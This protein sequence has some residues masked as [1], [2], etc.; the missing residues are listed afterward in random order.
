MEEL[1]KKYIEKLCESVPIFSILQA[2]RKVYS[3][4]PHGEYWLHDYLYTKLQAAFALDESTFKCDEFYCGFGEDHLLDKAVM[5]M[6]VNI[7]TDEIS[8]LR[9]LEDQKGL[10]EQ[11]A[12]HNDEL[13]GLHAAKNSDA[14]TF[15][16]QQPE[17]CA[18]EA[19]EQPV[20]QCAVEADE[21]PVETCAV[22]MLPEDIGLY[23]NWTNLEMKERKRR[24]RI[25][26]QKMLPV[27]NHSGDFHDDLQMVKIH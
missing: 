17:Q 9:S 1:A 8:S 23:I 2:T 22:T 11:M 14:D 15:V 3:K 16:E 7:Y 27:P 13:D 19:D 20:E 5:G 4:L 25:L 18:V 10:N 12:D 26:R 21:Q 24:K 6:L